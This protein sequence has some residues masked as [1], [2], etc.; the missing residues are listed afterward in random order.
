MSD[1]TF[2]L[3]GPDAPALIVINEAIATRQTRAD[4]LQAFKNEQGADHLYV[5]GER[6]EFY[7]VSFA[8]GTEIPAGWRPGD[9]Y[10]VPAKRTKAGKAIVQILEQIPHGVDSLG[11]T[12]M[13]ERSTTQTFTKWV[14]N[15]MFWAWFEL[16]LDKVVLGV[17]NGS[18][19]P[20]GCTELK[21][22]EYYQILEEAKAA[23]TVEATA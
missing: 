15:S 1:H 17:P 7:G 23:K 3:V 5:Q 18:D 10:Y 14:G 20:A 11:F 12:G 6:G 9:R 2:Y 21:M 4:L 22:S 16:H 19:V 13:L 8:E